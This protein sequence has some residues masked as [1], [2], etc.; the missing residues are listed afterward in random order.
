MDN[1]FAQDS[2]TIEQKGVDWQPFEEGGFSSPW[3]PRLWG[4]AIAANYLL[5]TLITVVVA[6]V[7]AFLSEQCQHWCLIP[8]ILCGVLSG[9]DIIAWLR[10]EIDVFDPKV[11]VAAFLYLNCFLAPI[12]HLRYG[13]YGETFYTDDWPAWFGYMACF[14]AAGIILLTLAQ[15]MAFKRF[16]PAKSF[17]STRNT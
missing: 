11:F 13:I 1:G 17:W 6:I 12:L 3:A 9:A 8:L 2:Y 15:H 10:K 7:F 16:K 14:N 5:S 4:G